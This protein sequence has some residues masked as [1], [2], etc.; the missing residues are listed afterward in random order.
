MH[1]LE[2]V[3]WWFLGKREYVRTILKSYTTKGIKILDVGSGT[4][5]MTKFLTEWGDVESLEKNFLA[6][7]LAKRRGLKIRY[8]SA[9]KLPFEDKK[10]DLVTI[11]DVLYHKGVEEKK[12]L[13]EA[14]RV[15]KKKGVIIITD[16]VGP[17]FW[18]DHDIK[19]EAKYRFTHHQAVFLVKEAG[20]TVK[21]SSF[22]FCSVFPLFFL[23]RMWQ[24]LFK[25]S[26]NIPVFPAFLNSFFYFLISIEAKLLPYINFPWGSS[27]LIVA[28][29]K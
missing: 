21:K 27:I 7:A 8:G 18:S 28:Q 4:G 16:C 25:Q 15:L 12:A 26:I 5:G 11:F 22:I 2:D 9:N 10:F 6:I 3:H 29:K 20:F 24:T 14:F 19:M 23:Q 13:Q 1:V 17:W